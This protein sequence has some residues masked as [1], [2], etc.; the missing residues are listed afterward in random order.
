MEAQRITLAMIDG[1]A[2]YEATPDRVRLGELAR[3]AEDV[4]TFL[5]GDSRDV[6]T[7]E[8]EVSIRKGSFAIETMPILSAPKL[9][10]D[11]RSLSS[12]ELLDRVDGKRKE[13]VERWQ[14][15]AKRTP[16]LAYQVTAAF[17][18]APV[19]IDAGTDYRADDADQWVQVE[20][21]IRGEIE[22]LGGAK[23]PNA[24]VRLPDGRSLTVSTER[25]LLRNEKD[26]RLYKTVMLR[27][28]ADYNVLSGELRNARLLQFVEYAND[29]DE[30][31]LKRLRKRGSEAWKD[32]ED[33]AAW[34]DELRGDKD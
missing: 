19:V 28:R 3:F 25:E 22:N 15:A 1:S 33:P 2:G 7:Q 12:A 8:L 18:N 20:R 27:I 26:N 5:R 34:V 30:A 21:Y 6:D 16:A 29:V 32:V 31:Q 9:F 4:Q 23:H 11:L 10:Q 24:H 17:L 13:V 14:K